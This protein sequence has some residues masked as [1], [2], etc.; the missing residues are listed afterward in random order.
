MVGML[1][2]KRLGGLEA[3]RS[4]PLE[5]N[6]GAALDEIQDSWCDLRATP[7]MRGALEARRR[8]LVPR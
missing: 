1:T 7:G 5:P 4:N 2:E 8:R 6:P 3:Q